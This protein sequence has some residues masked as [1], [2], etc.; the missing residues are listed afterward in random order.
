MRLIDLVPVALRLWAV[1]LV[2]LTIAGTA[3]GGAWM[4]QDWRYGK[5]LAEQAGQV[6]QAARKR[7]EYALAA[8]VD[9]RDKRGALEGRLQANDATHY[10]EL[11]DAKKTQQ[12]LSDR[13]ATADVRLSVLLAGGSG[14]GA[15]V[16]AAASA[17]GVVHGAAR[18]ELDPAHAQRIVGITSDGD[19]GLIALAA[20]Q[21]Y[22][23]EVSTPK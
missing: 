14:G 16:S 22:V 15:G 7:A 5:A 1:A 12:H 18:A 2:L 11:S 6:D 3:A 9:E 23:K 20:C 17:G 19:Q 8:L 4:A 13:L 10:K 21:A